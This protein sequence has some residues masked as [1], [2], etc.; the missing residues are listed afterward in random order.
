VGILK[1]SMMAVAAIGA[2]GAIAAGGSVPALAATTSGVRY[3]AVQYATTLGPNGTECAANVLS[4]AVSAGSPAYVSVMV[5]NTLTSDW[6]I[7][8][9][10][11]ADGREWYH[12]W[13]SAD[14]PSAQHNLETG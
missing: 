7:M 14:L 4:A 2:V 1:R 13:E 11:K 9:Y 5:Q 10:L 3:E 12:E 8:A 6:E